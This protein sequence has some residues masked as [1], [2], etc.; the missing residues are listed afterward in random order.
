M[1]LE[2]LTTISPSPQSVPPGSMAMAAPSRV[3][4]ACTA[5]GPA[6]TSVASAS[7][8]PDS[9]EPFA[10]K[11]LSPGKGGGG[12]GGRCRETR[13]PGRGVEGKNGSGF[14]S[15]SVE[16]APRLFRACCSVAK[17]CP[18]LRPHGLQHARLPC[19]SLSPRVCSHS[20]LLSW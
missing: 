11:V 19:P 15:G 3:P 13:S 7:A 4:S 2:P 5:A 16:A 14:S 9:P 12:V 10:I 17:S 18:T 6:T 8:S 20:C 1:P